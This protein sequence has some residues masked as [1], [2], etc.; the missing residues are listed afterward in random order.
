MESF[1]TVDHVSLTHF[2]KEAGELILWAG[3]HASQK[4][5]RLFRPFPAMLRF[6]VLQTAPHQGRVFPLATAGCKHFLHVYKLE[7]AQLYNC[8]AIIGRS[9]CGGLGD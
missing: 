3:K 5:H 7:V 1:L 9:L 8:T 6:A 4:N 2:I